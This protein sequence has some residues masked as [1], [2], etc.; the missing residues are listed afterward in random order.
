MRIIEKYLK[1]LKSSEHEIIQSMYNS[2]YKTGD[3]EDCKELFIFASKNFEDKYEV[4]KACNALNNMN[5]ED[6]NTIIRAHQAIL[7]TRC[8]V[9]KDIEDNKE[10]N[11]DILTLGRSCYI[12]TRSLFKIIEEKWDTLYYTY[13]PTT[14]KATYITYD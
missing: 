10:S 3:I 7:I 4:E 12:I 14:G 11:E 1:D 5:L 9:M 13:D 2:K 8:Q 6:E